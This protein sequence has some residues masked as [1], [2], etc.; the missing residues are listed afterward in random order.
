MKFLNIDHG[1]LYLFESENAYWEVFS[2][3]GQFWRHNRF[4]WIDFTFFHL[5]VEWERHVGNALT[6]EFALLGIFTRFHW[7]V[8]ENEGFKEIQNTIKEMK[9]TTEAHL[10]EKVALLDWFK[11]ILPKKGA[12]TALQKVDSKLKS[13]TKDLVEYKKEE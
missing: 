12:K 7:L 3:Y 5:D 2:Q 1:S 11:T 13:I 6:I 10:E 9:T 8:R 4:N